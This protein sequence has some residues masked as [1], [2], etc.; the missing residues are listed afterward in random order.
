MADIS[1][2]VLMAAQKRLRQRG[3]HFS[4]SIILDREFRAIWVA[5]KAHPFCDGWVHVSDADLFNLKDWTASCLDTVFRTCIRVI[6][7]RLATD[8]GAP[9]PDEWLACKVIEA[10][11]Q[12]EPRW[13][14]LSFFTEDAD[15][16]ECFVWFLYIYVNGRKGYIENGNND[17][18]NLS[19]CEAWL[20]STVDKLLL[21]FKGDASRKAA[22]SCDITQHKGLI[23]NTD[24]RPSTLDTNRKSASM[25]E[26]L[27]SN[28][29][30]VQKRLDELESTVETRF[31]QVC[32]KID[33][34][35][36]FAKEAMS[37]Q[38]LAESSSIKDL[39]TKTNDE[40]I[41]VAAACSQ[42]TEAVTTLI[43]KLDCQEKKIDELKT[44]A[45]AREVKAGISKKTHTIEAAMDKST[46][47]TGAGSDKESQT[48]EF[49]ES[50]HRQPLN[51]AA[52]RQDLQ[53][54]RQTASHAGPSPA[55]DT[56]SSGRH[57]VCR[58]TDLPGNLSL[59][60][61][62]TSADS[63]ETTQ[64]QATR[65]K[66]TVETAPSE[67]ASAK[68]YTP[69]KKDVATK[70]EN[71]T[72]LVDILDSAP[73]PLDKAVQ[74]ILDLEKIMASFSL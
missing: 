19:K 67:I 64:N 63:I 10:L 21:L 8:H 47:T 29:K 1:H 31:K 73:E 18:G 36:A 50:F 6:E 13:K 55:E 2:S 48:I 32:L 9:L 74:D 16:Q 23:P 41:S 4:E 69:G 24:A 51:A 12:T 30:H 17:P 49:E 57:N 52:T 7:P 25:V 46:Q 60:V 38:A 53:R 65:I 11:V 26:Q 56:H 27:N 54:V 72:S 44:R 62:P 70:Q 42:M 58:K 35:R 37:E 3:F 43:A 66:T 71:A 34:Q 33:A 45:N 20:L 61:L 22:A 39:S 40:L 68:P 15:D 59:V 14:V 5:L 28:V